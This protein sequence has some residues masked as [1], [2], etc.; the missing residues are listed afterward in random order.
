MA[1]SVD[2][3][4]IKRLVSALEQIRDEIDGRIDVEDRPDGSGVRPNIFM[5]IDQII[6]E[7]L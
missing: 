6:E 1:L 4:F 3:K 5:R 2:E 7:V